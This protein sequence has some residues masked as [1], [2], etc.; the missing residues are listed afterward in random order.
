MK[1][2]E[3]MSTE[4]VT[5]SPGDSLD[6]AA[7]RMW[8]RDCGIL[9]VVDDG[10]V[11]GLITDRDIAMTLTIKGARPSAVTVAEVIDGHSIYSCSPEADV[12]EALKVM[13]DRQVRRLPVMEDG[14]L[15]GLLSMN[16]VALAARETPGT[17]DWPTYGEVIGALQGIC[18]HRPLATA[19]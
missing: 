19:A 9:P 2:K 1:V 11:R 6:V 8:D 15:R 5:C 10:R 14:R 7:K 4:P 13:H 16:D 17:K 18:A 3:L 12:A